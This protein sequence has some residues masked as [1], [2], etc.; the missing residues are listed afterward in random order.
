MTPSWSTRPGPYVY[1]S[2]DAFDRRH[3]ADAM[4]V[5]DYV[6]ALRGGLA[7]QYGTAPQP[8]AFYVDFDGLDGQLVAAL[9][10]V[11]FDRDGDRV[12]PPADVLVAA[13]VTS[14]IVSDAGLAPVVAADEVRALRLDGATW[15]LIAQGRDLDAGNVRAAADRALARRAVAEQQGVAVPAVPASAPADAGT[16]PRPD[17]DDPALLRRAWTPMVGRRTTA[18]PRHRP[19][20]RTPRTN[21]ARSG[22]SS[23]RPGRP[24]C[25][26]TT[27]AGWSTTSWTRATTCSAARTPGRA[28]R[29]TPATRNGL[30]DA[31]G[32]VVGGTVDTLEGAVGTVLGR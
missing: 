20:G 30:L 32:D 13:V 16:T 9:G 24:T 5:D 15:G 8:P 6:A 14:A 29:P 2:D 28:A 4:A 18:V 1:T 23:T 27:S 25:S 31:T 11:G 17:A 10:D 22:R 21:P 7:A 12:G 26:V 3:L 19:T